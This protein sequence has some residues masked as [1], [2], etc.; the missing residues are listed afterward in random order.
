MSSEKIFYLPKK[1]RILVGICLILFSIFPHTL[2]GLVVRDTT[3]VDVFLIIGWFNLVWFIFLQAGV[4]FLV[5][6]N[7]PI[8]IFNKNEFYYNEM[9]MPS[10]RGDGLFFILFPYWYRK[11]THSIKYSD[12]KDY[13]CH[14][15]KWF[16]GNKIIF[17]INSKRFFLEYDPVLSLN[18][19]N[20]TQINTIQIFLKSKVK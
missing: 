19:F 3:I 15:S 18:I 17:K 6:K 8:L 9:F 20:K 1:N 7:L 11:L 10:G 4:S 2:L 13:Q 16:L 14:G 12:I 5:F